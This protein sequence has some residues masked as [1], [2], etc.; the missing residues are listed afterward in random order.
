MVKHGTQKKRRAGRTGK[1]KIK[2]R[3]F[4]KF[5]PPIFAD[6]KVKAVW[7]KTKSP[8]ANMAALGLQ[9]DVN[10][11]HITASAS[12]SKKVIELF[13]IPESGI[14]PAKTYSQ[15]LLPMSVNDQKY[16]LPLLEEHGSN[17]KAMERDIKINKMQYTETKLSNMAQKFLSLTNEQRVVDVSWCLETTARIWN[18]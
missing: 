7:N 14:I 12:N 13:D 11:P 15:I 2:N 18:E 4:S 3:S 1:I 6:E 17:Y 9:S 5:K 16:I 10:K 8:T